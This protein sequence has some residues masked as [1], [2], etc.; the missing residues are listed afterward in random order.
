MPLRTPI[1]LDIE[2]LLSQAEYHEINVP[3]QADIVEKTVRKR[4]GRGRVGMS[5]VGVDASVGKDVEQQTTYR[6]E[7]QV[8]A[9]VSRV[10]DSLAQIKAVTVNPDEG[11][12]LAKDDLVEIEGLT[13]IT[14]ASLAGKMFFIFRRLMEAADGDPDDIFDLDI[15]SLPIAEQLKQVYLLNELLPIPVL[16]EMTRTNLPLKVY[17]NVRPNHFVDAASSDRVEGDLR[18]LGTVT[19][20]IPGGDEGFFSAEEWLLHDWEYLMRRQLMT[21]VD[22]VVKEMVTGLELDLPAEDVHAHISGPALVVD[23]IALY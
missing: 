20:L 4:S 10:I 18:V 5:G 14:G 13:R 16:L 11:T 6:L 21:Q 9:T 23:A 15:D 19:R 7:P 1:Y 8:K 3:R 2:T 17:I 22:E 12:A